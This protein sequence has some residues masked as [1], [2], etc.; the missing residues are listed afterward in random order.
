MRVIFRTGKNFSNRKIIVGK[1]IL[2]YL[3][4]CGITADFYTEADLFLQLPGLIAT[5][6]TFVSHY[7]IARR[8]CRH[9]ALHSFCSYVSLSGLII[10]KPA[11]RSS[12]S[13]WS[14]RI[15]RSDRS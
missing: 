8:L 9:L 12:V 1:I 7:L 13:R 3:N 6:I 11:V 5:A 2:I 14:V 15:V 10:A 4:N